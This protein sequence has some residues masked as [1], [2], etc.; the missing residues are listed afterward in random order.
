MCPRTDNQFNELREKSK[1]NILESALNLFSSKGF[2][3]TSI[4]QI[5]Q[6]ANVSN[7]L[8]YNYF[9]SKENLLIEIINK[10][11][12]LIDSILENGENLTAEEKIVGTIE[13]TFN[14]IENKQKILRMM[15]QIGLQTEKFDFVNK[16][17]SNEIIIKVSFTSH[18]NNL[19]PINMLKDRANRPIII[20]NR[21][22]KNSLFL[23]TL[24]I[25][26]SNEYKY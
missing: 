3:N 21:Y 16:M 1:E 4:R 17:I 8:M 24:Y 13:K 10:T 11:F 7:G 15:I 19:I 12:K 26:L 2:F 14:V 5:A 23:N 22:L 18:L 25:M 20:V 9:S 6:K